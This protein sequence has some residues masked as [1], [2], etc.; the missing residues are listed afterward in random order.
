ME[1]VVGGYV[2]TL[3]HLLALR[4]CDLE[5]HRERDRRYAEVAVEREKALRIKETADDMA[6]QLARADQTFKN[7]AA[8]E[9]RS[10]IERE[11]GSYATHVELTAAMEKMEALIAPLATWAAAQQGRSSGLSAGWGFL[12]GVV[13]VAAAVISLLT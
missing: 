10:Q 7:E 4:A 2:T 9:L 8:N 13:G 11:R 12:V 3:E 5:L 6:R 1:S